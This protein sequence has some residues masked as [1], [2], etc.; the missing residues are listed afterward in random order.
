MEFMH[1]CMAVAVSTLLAMSAICH[2][3]LLDVFRRE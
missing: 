2:C 1:S 3:G